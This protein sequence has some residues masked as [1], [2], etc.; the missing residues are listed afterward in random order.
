MHLLNKSINFNKNKTES[1]MENATHSF[2]ETNLFLSLYKNWKL[3][4]E[5]WRAG[6]HK[7]KKEGILTFVFYP[8]A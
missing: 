5:L 2:R 8:N 3:K 7:I 4:M 6:A 1:K